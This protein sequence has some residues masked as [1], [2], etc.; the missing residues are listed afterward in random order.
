MRNETTLNRTLI[1][2]LNNWLR[3]RYDDASNIKHYVGDKGNETHLTTS[4][5]PNT[6]QHGR[7]FAGYTDELY[8]EML[9]DKHSLY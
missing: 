3:D 1:V 6:S 5:M 8:S 4:R 2:K 7:I 9:R